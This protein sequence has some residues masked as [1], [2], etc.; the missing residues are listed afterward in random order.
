MRSKFLVKLFITDFIVTYKHK[1][2]IKHFSLLAMTNIYKDVELF[3]FKL[4][5]TADHNSVVSKIL[6]HLIYAIKAIYLISFHS[7]LDV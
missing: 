2:I 7:C 1:Q 3:I 5:F 6:I 4:H